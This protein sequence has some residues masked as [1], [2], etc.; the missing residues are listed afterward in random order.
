[1]NE[2][3]RAAL[4]G[5]DI[6]CERFGMAL[7]RV[8]DFDHYDCDDLDKV[9]KLNNSIRYR[10][11]DMDCVVVVRYSGYGYNVEVFIHHTQLVDTEYPAT[12][13]G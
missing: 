12:H 3:K 1:M 5:L 9:E 11:L 6:A 13:L 4:Y 2:N 7:E 8:N 10:Y